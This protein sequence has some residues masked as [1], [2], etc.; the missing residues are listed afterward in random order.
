MPRGGGFV[1]L[2]RVAGTIVVNEFGTR[3]AAKGTDK[4][5][6]VVRM[7]SAGATSS[8]VTDC[9]SVRPQGVGSRVCGSE[10][11]CHGPSIFQLPVGHRRCRVGV[12]PSDAC[13]L[14]RASVAASPASP[15]VKRLRFRRHRVAA[16][17]HHCRL[18]GPPLPPMPSP[19][20]PHPRG[21]TPAQRR[22]HLPGRGK[23]SRA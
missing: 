22:W 23:G 14:G 16:L 6:G 13:G 21:R 12:T 4:I 8:Q 19:R 9:R 15:R 2:G 7:Q 3:G 18:Q 11:P 5:V 17:P 10:F 20:K 1:V